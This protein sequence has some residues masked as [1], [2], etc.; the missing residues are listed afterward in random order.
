M[1]AIRSSVCIAAGIVA[2]LSG[3]ASLNA[4]SKSAEPILPVVSHDACPGTRIVPNWKIRRRATLFSSWKRKSAA[5]A[6]L[7]P[8]DRVTVLAGVIVTYRPDIISVRQPMPDLS[9]VPGDRIFR[10]A[11][12]VDG[13]SDIWAKGVWHSHYS[14]LGTI[15]KFDAA[16]CRDACESVVVE[17]GIIDSF[18]QV[19]TAKNITGWAL[20]YRQTGDKFEPNSNFA[21]L[22]VD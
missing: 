8:G 16:E 5:I 1:A 10:Y 7:M 11:Y 22:C 6:T 18:V 15:E 4:Q 21:E 14:L 13:E 2:V 3:V 12:Y 19:R 17:Q 9:L 20:V